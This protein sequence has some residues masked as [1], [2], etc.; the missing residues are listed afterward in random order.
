M[1]PQKKTS[2]VRLNNRRLQAE[3]LEPRLVLST[4]LVTT[5]ND[6]GAG[7]LRQAIL[8]ANAATGADIVEFDPGLNGTLLLTSGK[9]TI[10]D[11]LVVDGPGNDII[12]VDG[13]NQVYNGMFTI[14][15]GDPNT[16]T[17]V[18]LHGLTLTRARGGDFG[19]AVFAYDNVV[20]SDSIVTGNRGSS[21]SE[22]I[23]SFYADLTISNSKIANNDQGGV[24]GY[25]A[26]V[27]IRDSTISGNRDANSNGIYLDGS[28]LTISNSNVSDHLRAGIKAARSEI[29]IKNST[30]S[31][32]LGQNNEGGISIFYGSANIEH[33]TISGN[34]A[35]IHSPYA[36][37]DVT[38]DHTIVANNSDFDVSPRHITAN[39]SLIE[40]ASGVTITGAN[41][42]TGVDPLLGPLVD[43]GGPTYTHALLTGSPAIDAGDPTAVAGVGDVPEFDQ[44]G[45]PFGR[46]QDGIGDMTARIDMGAYER[47]LLQDRRAILTD[48]TAA[49]SKISTR[50]SGKLPRDSTTPFTI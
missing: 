35:G 34:E 9:L 5:L 50:W 45:M 7:S 31:G 49:T 46:V 29:T 22:A 36:V 30:I 8:D 43:N 19:S 2:I 15:D 27:D 28:R 4:L 17:Q 18:V 6:S 13:G 11:D 37:S 33:S 10:T 32:N 16:A 38:L 41:N 26:N 14:N 3:S 40:N 20:I 21:G 24:Y 47:N 39:F 12:R 1:K 42:L 44:R 25:Y 23:A 48:W